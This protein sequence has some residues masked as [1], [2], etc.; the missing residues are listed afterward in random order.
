LAGI[1]TDEPYPREEPLSWEAFQPASLE[2]EPLGRPR[3][4][5]P[6]DFADVIRSRRSRLAGPVAWSRV[7][8]L[9]WHAAGSNGYADS[10]RAGLPIEWRVS[11]SAGGLHPVRLV[12]INDDADFRPRLYNSV[13]H[14]FHILD[15]D[16]EDIA[17][18]NA[19]AV[20]AVVGAR[21]GCTVRLIADIGKV[22]AAYENADSL[23]LRDAGCLVAIFCLCAEWL[24]LAACP[25]GFLGDDM[26]SP[27][28]FPQPRFRAVGGV[29]ITR[30]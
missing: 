21:R 6:R 15:V 18:K 30:P 23:V 11:P 29:Q 4:P 20:A 10:G 2:T 24:D 26:V 7:A 14:A 28:G 5:G 8:E 27:L 16:G 12:C 3:S 13:D 25:L 1:R 19:A 22:A 17:A 9:L